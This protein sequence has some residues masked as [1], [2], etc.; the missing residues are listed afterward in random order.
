MAGVEAGCP[1]VERWE[2]IGIF[3]QRDGTRLVGRR[4]PPGQIYRHLGLNQFESTPSL[5]PEGFL[6]EACAYNNWARMCVWNPAK[7]RVIPRMPPHPAALG[8]V[9]FPDENGGREFAVYVLPLVDGGRIEDGVKSLSVLRVPV[10]CFVHRDD[11]H[12]NPALSWQ[13]PSAAWYQELVLTLERPERV[14][15]SHDFIE[16]QH[17][18]SIL[19]H[20]AA[21]RYVLIFGMRIVEFQSPERVLLSFSNLDN[22]DVPYPVALTASRA[23]FLLDLVWV[24]RAALADPPCSLRSD[25]DWAGAYV[26]FYRLGLQGTP[27]EGVRQ[28][29]AEARL[30]ELGDA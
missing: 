6:E 16:G 3:V 13:L 9:F 12:R 30:A 10:D 24:P 22:N 21:E 11:D 5:L 28:L 23:L 26:H 17:G 8:E 4:G 20:A 1:P 19:V 27:L 18:C 29:A 15:I 25:E 14:W 2:D 7:R